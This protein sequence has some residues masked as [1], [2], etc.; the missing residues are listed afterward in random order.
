MGGDGAGPLPQDNGSGRVML[1]KQTHP[2]VTEP[3][4]WEGTERGLPQTQM[5]K[6]ERTR[7]LL[8][9]C[10]SAKA[11][12][13][14]VSSGPGSHPRSA[15][16]GIKMQVRRPTFSSATAIVT[17]AGRTHLSR[18]PLSFLFKGPQIVSLFSRDHCRCKQELPHHQLV[19]RLPGLLPIFF[20]CGTT[21]PS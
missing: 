20:W 1:G 4:Q 2:E 12:G 15:D 3:Q 18:A 16:G 11:Y 17:D 7:K 8:T 5:K 14:I 13:R 6:Q 10:F 9:K 19:L 21:P